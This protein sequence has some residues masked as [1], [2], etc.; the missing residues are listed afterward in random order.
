MFFTSLVF[1]ARHAHAQISVTGSQ[2]LT[3]FSDEPYY[4]YDDGFYRFIY[5]ASDR[6]FIGDLVFFNEKIR[7]LYQKDFD[8]RFDER[9]TLILASNRNQ[10]A[11]GLTTAVP[12]LFTIFYPGGAEYPDEFT[13]NSWVHMLLSH[14]TSHLY[15]L[16]Q[17]QGYSAFLKKYFGNTSLSSNAFEIPLTYME[18]PNI[19][20]PTFLLEGNAVLNESQ[21]GNGGRLFNG[22]VRAEVL[23]LAK[24]GKINSTRLMNNHLYFPFTQEKYWV[25]GY[26][27]AW[28]ADQFGIERV[29]HYYHWHAYNY[30]N[31][32]QVNNAFIETFGFGYE[33]AIQQFLKSWQPL[34][35]TQKSAAS[36]TLFTSLAEGDLSKEGDEIRFL[37]TDDETLPIVHIYNIKN[38][39][40][41]SQRIDL[42]IGRVFRDEKGR[43]V[44]VS[45]EQIDN[46]NIKAGLFGDGYSFRR[47]SENKFIYDKQGR[48]VLYA[49]ANNSFLRFSLWS[50]YDDQLRSGHDDQSP[51]N[52]TKIGV[53][54]SAAI[55]GP[56]LEPYYFRQE[57]DNRVL[58]KGNQPLFS[59]KGYWGLP[60][61]AEPSGAV[62]FIGPVERGA[63]LFKWQ[64]GTITRMTD[65]DVI[66][67]AELIDEHSAVVMEISATGYNY[68][69]IS[70]SERPGA[71][72]EYK[73]KFED[74]P[75][76]HLFDQASVTSTASAQSPAVNATA[77]TTPT[78]A[79]TP[80][81]PRHFDKF[82]PRLF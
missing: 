67:D 22:E 47:S 2:K 13:A 53:T 73:Y 38:H 4:V 18:Y 77:A 7:N 37:T 15:Q 51:K 33:N 52:Q 62:Y 58:Y 3:V 63:S 35:S 68:K 19:Y 80:T 12:R 65:S 5:P 64:N 9:P 66:V 78:S 69:I 44:S 27:E 11:N 82:T 60:V 70:L 39:T 20:L 49:D 76:F 59:Y 48:H 30:I 36:P 1:S 14:E 57:N 72:V 46:E 40:W 41:W 10:V 28:L 26:L 81:P 32:L 8:W 21:F 45:S 54:S 16:D 6:P 43:L 23:A 24:A 71:P 25:G 55:F 17:K 34:Y 75:N 29:D 31:P 56:D 74:S 61:E 50:G 42:P 79:P